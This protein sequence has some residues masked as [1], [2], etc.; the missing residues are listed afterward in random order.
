[1][2][3]AGEI[4]L[5]VAGLRAQLLALMTRAK[6]IDESLQLLTHSQTSLKTAIGC[7]LDSL[8]R[9]DARLRRQKAAQKAPQEPQEP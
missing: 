6:E 8:D 4:G 2:S 9:I 7:T 1:M 5:E 3:F